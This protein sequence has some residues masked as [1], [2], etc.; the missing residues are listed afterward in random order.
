MLL[1]EVV[2]HFLNDWVMEVCIKRNKGVFEAEMRLWCVLHYTY[3]SPIVGPL[4]SFSACIFY[5]L[6]SSHALPLY[7]FTGPAILQ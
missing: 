6:H 1:G 2:G 3:P 7:R 5:E 4:R